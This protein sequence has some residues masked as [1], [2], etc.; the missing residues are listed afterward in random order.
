MSASPG[1]RSRGTLAGSIAFTASSSRGI[2]SGSSRRGNNR[3]SSGRQGGGGPP[4]PDWT[5]DEEEEEEKEGEEEEEGEECNARLSVSGSPLATPRH[6]HQTLLEADA[7]SIR[8]AAA[9]GQEVRREI[10]GVTK[11]L[12]QVCPLSLSLPPLSLCL[13]STKPMGTSRTQDFRGKERE[14]KARYETTIAAGQ[15]RERA[16]VVAVGPLFS[17]SQAPAVCL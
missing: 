17:V 10:E 5:D 13:P 12:M 11:V 7:G 3:T 15:V 14:L 9:S 4:S 8:T 1:K 6:L 2:A 16:R